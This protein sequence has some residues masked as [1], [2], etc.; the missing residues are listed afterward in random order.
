[1]VCLPGL[2]AAVGQSSTF[3]VWSG[4]CAFVKSVSEDG[5]RDRNSD[6]IEMVSGQDLKSPNPVLDHYNIK[7]LQGKQKHSEN[8]VQQDVC[9]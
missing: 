6:E 2:V 3:Y 1:M 8:K 5:D 4:H 7:G 9:N